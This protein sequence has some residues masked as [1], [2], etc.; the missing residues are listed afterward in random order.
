MIPKQGLDLAYIREAL[1]RRFWYVAVPFFLISLAA[2]LYCIFTPRTF[3]AQTVILVEPQRVP[4]EYVSSTVTIDLRSRLRTIT[5]QVKSRTRLEKI[6]AEY[7]LYPETRATATMTDA[8]ETF[9]KNIDVE[10]RGGYQAFEVSFKGP[11]PVKVRDVTN[12]IANQ[13]IEDNLRLREAQAAGTTQFLD[14]E[15]ERLKQILEEKDGALRRFKEK[16]RGLLPENMDQNYR[17]MSHLQQQLDSINTTIQQTKDRRILLESQLGNLQRMS[18]VDSAEGPEKY[19]V[20]P[21]DLSELRLRLKNLR[22]RYSDKHP[23]VINTKAAIER[24]EKDLEEEKG[25]RPSEEAAGSGS[26]PGSSES[27][28]SEG[29]F[30]Y[31]TEQMQDLATQIRLI[32]QEMNQLRQKKDETEKELNLYRSRVEEGP[33]IEQMLLDLKRGYAEVDNNYRSLLDKKFK[34]KLA[35]NLEVSQQG[36]QFTILDLAALP[37]KPYKPDVRKALAM[38]LLLALCGGLGL[39]VLLEYLDSSFYSAK[40]LENTLK[41]PALISIPLITTIEDRRRILVTRAVSA[42]ALISMASVLLYALYFLWKIDPM[43]MALI[44]S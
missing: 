36:E 31:S 20:V 30:L 39:A 3:K 42:V 29:A 10:V 9:R 26:E 13:F 16:Y 33:K 14:R 11:D 38:G 15:M 1:H 2:L 25:R 12:T 28:P 23:D 44:G 41:L 22:A 7:D 6:I 17:M 18:R 43:A 19:D 8:V 4:G 24:L 35:E 21:P 40:E 32:D 27:R 5:Q 37:D 34:A